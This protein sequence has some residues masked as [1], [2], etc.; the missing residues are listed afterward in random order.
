MESQDIDTKEMNEIW[1][2]AILPVS[3]TIEQA[4]RNLNDVAIKIVLVVD[5]ANQL[6]GTISDGDIRRGLLKGLD[7]NNAVSS[8]INKSA[9]VVPL[10]MG[11]DTVLQ[12]MAANNLQQIPVVDAKQQLVGLHLWN[13]VSV[14]PIRSNLMVIMA[15]GKGLR[16]MPHTNS[17]PK[18]LVEVAGKPMLEHII[19]S[20][21]LEGFNHFVIA[22]Y[23][24]GHMIEEYF[25]N[26]ERLGVKIDYLREKTP[27]G[28][29]GALS[30]LNSIPEEPFVITNGDLVTDISYGALL[31]FHERHKASATMAVRVHEWQHP[32]GVVQ[33]QGVDITGFDEKPL[34]RSHINAGVYVLSP[35]ALGQL[36]PGAP[37]DMPMLFERLKTSSKRTV[38]YPMHEP[39]L[40]VGR[41]DD[42]IEANETLDKTRAEKK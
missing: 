18:P 40:D 15:G 11:R 19:E 16:L 42:L 1:R 13:K 6:I 28:T 23:H 34:A 24:L 22:I 4:I 35:E 8:I 30:L 29:V 32:F 17:C 10:E 21:K 25:G 9:L 2:Q 33:T 5:K 7:L 36:T 31:D 41:P 37:C 3:S 26:G 27:L 39:W 38:A 12:L 20:G 14:P